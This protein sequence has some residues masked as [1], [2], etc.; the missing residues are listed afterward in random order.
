MFISFAPWKQDKNKIINI[1]TIY[2]E[3]NYK[4]EKRENSQYFM[5]AMLTGATHVTTLTMTIQQNDD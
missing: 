3:L 4:V 5:A 1:T 2:A